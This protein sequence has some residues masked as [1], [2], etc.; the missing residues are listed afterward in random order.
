MRPALLLDVDGV[1][2]PFDCP[3]GY[4]QYYLPEGDWVYAS[5][6]NAERLN[7]LRHTFDLVWCTGWGSLA[8]ERLLDLHALESPL[9]VIDLTEPVPVE[10]DL[11]HWKLPWIEAWL[12]KR[13]RPVAWIDD[14]IE[15]ATL[16]WAD[17]RTE[18][19]KP[20]LAL[21]IPPLTG[22]SDE[23]VKILEGWW[24]GITEDNGDGP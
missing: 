16:A 2:C 5:S 3:E 12:A 20:T 24:D 21:P 22:L 17:A 9:P 23:H 14:E 1:L 13:S 19:G 15:F 4:T 10:R 6:A 8:N 11:A 7:R 18:A